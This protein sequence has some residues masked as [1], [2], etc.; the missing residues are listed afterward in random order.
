VLL[1]GLVRVLFEVQQSDDGLRF[2]PRAPLATAP[3]GE[4]QFGQPPGPAEARFLGA[5]LLSRAGTALVLHR[6]SAEHASHIARQLTRQC[7]LQVGLGAYEGEP[8]ADESAITVSRR[9]P[10]S[11]W[12]E[13][14][15]YWVRD[16]DGPPQLWVQN[17]GHVFR[18]TERVLTDLLLR[19]S[20]QRERPAPFPDANYELAARFGELASGEVAVSASSR[21]R[22]GTGRLTLPEGEVALRA[23]ASQFSVR[24]QPDPRRA[25]IVA[26]R[27]SAAAPRPDP[28]ELSVTLPPGWWLVYAR[29]MTGRWDRVRDPVGL[30][31]LA[32]GRRR[33][34]YEFS[35]GEEPIHLSF[36]LA[37]L[38]VPSL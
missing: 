30:V 10:P 36:D 27:V 32:D 25:G 6:G 29:D 14:G 19:V 38:E 8:P 2:L 28:A 35:A 11:G 16:W 20:P 12:T 21:S 33:L 1:A 26:L 15:G 5:E 17:K 3:P 13:S 34:S 4:R 24:A 22:R 31:G 7:N 9:H 18:D 23:G 37:R